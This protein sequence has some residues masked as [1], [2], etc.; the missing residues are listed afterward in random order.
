MSKDTDH[1]YYSHNRFTEFD[2]VVVDMDNGHVFKLKIRSSYLQFS[3][4]YINF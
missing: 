2:I 4:Q 3:K 1:S